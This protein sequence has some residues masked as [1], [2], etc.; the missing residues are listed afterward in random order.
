M[1]WE[2]DQDRAF[3]CDGATPHEQ[4]EG[5]IEYAGLQPEPRPQLFAGHPASQR[6]LLVVRGEDALDLADEPFPAGGRHQESR[7]LEPGRAVVV[8]LTDIQNHYAVLLDQP[9]DD[10]LHFGSGERA[11]LLQR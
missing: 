4:P 11:A 7:R 3:L 10:G 9:T 6:M 1:L 2:T 8:G 5:P